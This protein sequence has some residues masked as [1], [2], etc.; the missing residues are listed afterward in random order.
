LGGGR[1]GLTVVN[2]LDVMGTIEANGGSV[3][4]GGGGGGSGGSIIIKAAQM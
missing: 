2:R 1:V 4:E 3:S